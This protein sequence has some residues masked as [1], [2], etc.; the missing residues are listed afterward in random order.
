MYLHLNITYTDSV[1]RFRD[2]NK[3][4]QGIYARL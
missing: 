1:E 4:A 2:D 3:R